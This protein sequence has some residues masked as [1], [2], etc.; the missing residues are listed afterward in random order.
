MDWN[1]KNPLTLINLPLQ[2]AEQLFCLK[3][4][5]PFWHQLLVV[6]KFHPYQSKKNE[7]IVFF[8]FVNKKNKIIAVKCM[9]INIYISTSCS[10]PA[11]LVAKHENCAHKGSLIMCR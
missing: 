7:I 9:Q 3:N 5:D 6:N 11:F 4:I 10:N 2:F 1:L 8:F